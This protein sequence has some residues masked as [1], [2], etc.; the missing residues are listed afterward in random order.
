MARSSNR[1]PSSARRKVFVDRGEIPLVTG[2]I[3]AGAPIEP[4]PKR[5]IPMAEP[6]EP[7]LP[8]GLTPFP[9]PE[10]NPPHLPIDPL[11]LRWP[12]PEQ[13]IL[14]RYRICR[15]ALPQGCYELKVSP[16]N[17]FADYY[18]TLRVDT[19]DGPLTASGDLYRYQRPFATLSHGEL[20]T[21]I[22]AATARFGEV[23]KAGARIGSRYRKHTIPIYPINRYHSYLKVTGVQLW[24][25][26][27]RN[28]IAPCNATITAEQYLYT[29]P[30]AG[31]FDG[32]FSPA[33]GARTV[34]FSLHPVAGPTGYGGPHL[35]G[36]LM[37]GGV[38]CGTVE[39]QWVSKYFRKCTVEIDTL[40]GSV[41]PQAVPAH[42]G[43]RAAAAGLANE[44]FRS[45]FASAG[46]DAT[47]NYDQTAVAVPAGVTATS[48]WSSAAL[49]AL[50]LTIRK[51]TTNLDT[52]WHLHCVVVPAAMGCGRGVMYDTIQVPR[53]GV[54]SFSDDGYPSSQSSNFGTAANKLQRNTPRAF[55]RSCSHEMIHGFNQIHQENEGGGDNSIMTTTPSVADVL[56]SATTGEAGVFPDDI[57]LEVNEHVRHHLIHMP[58]ICVRPGGMTFGSGHGGGF[59]PERDRYVFGIDELMLTVDVLENNVAIGEPVQIRYR[60]TN[61]GTESLPVPGDISIESTYATITVIDPKGRS[62]PMPTFVIAPDTDGMPTLA[63]GESREAQT[64]VFWSTQ[65][66]GFTRPGTH[67]IDVAIMWT[68]D[69]IPCLVRGQASVVVSAPLTAL[70]DDAASTLLHPQVGMFVALGGGAMH[71]T[72]AVE[73]LDSLTG[74]TR[75]GAG[76]GDARKGRPKALRGF[77]G[78]LPPSQIELDQPRRERVTTTTTPKPR[79]AKAT[80]ASGRRR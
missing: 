20:S 71:L 22:S 73:R 30:P 21:A 34:T 59:V 13:Q 6:I 63:P 77:D 46:W 31:S 41:A 24:S 3:G 79:T 15:V 5:E 17:E 69:G 53:E 33:P 14:E 27:P 45:V 61:T 58:D 40:T 23:S 8:A 57:R 29:Q 72:E 80:S 38:D 25:F 32:T 4:A 1:E 52:E 49:H 19:E 10:G 37:V 35:S 47:I 2:P 26:V 18:G 39:L 67:V 75:G 51:P 7:Q 44:D 36:S 66:F 78:L 54:A 76:D 11:E 64:R 74:G 48:C 9:D 56:G 28:S 12:L 43:S 16:N 68:A 60:V 55:L 70:D 50:M 42:A 62:K 65:G